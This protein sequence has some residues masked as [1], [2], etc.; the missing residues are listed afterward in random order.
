M[1]LL[2]VALVVVTGLCLFAAALCVAA[3]LADA[4]LERERR[5]R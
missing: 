2:P 4:E 5:R 1:I 3:K